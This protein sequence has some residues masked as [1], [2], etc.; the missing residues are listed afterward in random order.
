MQM[1]R[2]RNRPDEA[3]G[4]DHVELL[5]PAVRD[6]ERKQRQERLHAV[7]HRPTA[8]D[9]RHR[10]EGVA[11]VG[12]HVLDRAPPHRRARLAEHRELEDTQH[13]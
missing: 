6:C 10:E 13:G 1:E 5:A 3:G 4:K 11:R 8:E 7:G 12:L 9:P 2:R